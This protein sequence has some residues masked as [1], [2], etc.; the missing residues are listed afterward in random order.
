MKRI[1]MLAALCCAAVTG[2]DSEPTPISA[3]E[4]DKI[5]ALQIAAYERLQRVQELKLDL[6]K[7]ENDF[8]AA[9]ARIMDHVR[10]LYRRVGVNDQVFQLTP[11]LSWERIKA[12]ATG[13]KKK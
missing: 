11:T 4:R 6:L 1:L 5:R 9:N 2:T 7:A 12:E 10:D 13:E 8:A 3:E